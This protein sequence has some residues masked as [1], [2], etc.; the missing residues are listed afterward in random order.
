MKI[1]QQA[2]VTT[3]MVAAALVLTGCVGAGPAVDRDTETAAPAPSASASRS[4]ADGQA[5]FEKAAKDAVDIKVLSVIDP[6]TFRVAPSDEAQ[7]RNHLSGELTVT[8]FDDAK[9]VTPKPDECGYDKALAFATQYFTENPEAGAIVSGSFS[10]SSYFEAAL[11]AG[12]AYIPDVTPP[13]AI[14]Q[15]EGQVAD[16]SLWVTCP[17][18]GD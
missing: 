9:L 2:R 5:A 17:G 1:A 18:F 12:V 6:R 4:G 10:S 8:L 13:L 7:A 16:G 3:I 14:A 15:E 11:R